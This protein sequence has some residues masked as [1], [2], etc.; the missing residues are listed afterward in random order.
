MRELLRRRPFRLLWIG[1]TLSAFGDYAMFLAFG[2]WAKDLTGSNA[3]AGL[4]LLPMMVPLLF[5]PALGIVADRFPRRRV[6]IAADVVAA[7]VMCCLLFV[8]DR[9][10][11]WLLYTVG[12]A[13][14]TVVTVYQGARSGLLVSMLGDE[15]LLGDANGLLHSSSQAMRL[16][17]P[18]VGAGLFAAFGGQAVALLDAVTFLVSAV[19]LGLVRADDIERRT[20]RIRVWPQTKEGLAHILATADLRRLTIGTSLVTLI[21]G[22]SEVAIF[23]VVDDGLGRQ[24]EFLGLISAVQ[25][26]GSIATGFLVGTLI[27]R[28][29]ALRGMALAALA[30]MVAEGLFGL[31][32]LPLVFVGAIAGGVASTL[33]NVSYITLMQTRTP[34]DLQGR[35]MSAVE[36]VVTVPFLMSLA[37]GALLITIVDFRVLYAIVAVGMALI[38]AYFWRAAARTPRETPVEAETPVAVP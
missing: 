33:F 2:I 29:G 13:Y 31:A 28:L 14:G 3:A 30:G 22:L 12:L 23:A 6:M 9:G 19:F 24:P 18:L 21:I 26:V 16:I 25:G 10:D 17:A 15:S 8:H 20:G 36:A 38:G 35:V 1:Q 4:A 32:V 27:R 11:L 7:G 37:L 5:G 34:M